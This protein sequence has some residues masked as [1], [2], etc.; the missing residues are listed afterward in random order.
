MEGEDTEPLQDKVA[1]SNNDKEYHP[2]PAS[3][4]SSEIHVN[5]PE[6]VFIISKHIIFQYTVRSREVKKY[7]LIILTH[8]WRVVSG[9]MCIEKKILFDSSLNHG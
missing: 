1:K 2:D 9:R 7:F 4:N 5:L 6:Q 3:N 8:L